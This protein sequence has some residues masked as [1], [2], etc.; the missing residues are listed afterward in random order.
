MAWRRTRYRR[1][2]PAQRKR[3][4]RRR[5]SLRRRRR[6]PLRPT[7][8]VTYK[9]QKIDYDDVTSSGAPPDGAGIK[10]AGMSVQISD[11]TN[12]SNEATRWDQF[13]IRKCRI[14]FI[15][16]FS[17]FDLATMSNTQATISMSHMPIIGWVVDRD[18]VT[19]PDTMDY[20]SRHGGKIRL[21]NKT[22][23]VTFTPTPLIDVYKAV[24]SANAVA[25]KPMWIDCTN[26]STPHYGLKYIIL[27]PT[28]AGT[29]TS[30][31]PYYV[32]TE[33]WVS[34]RNKLWATNWGN[35]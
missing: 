20:I 11:N 33:W 30:W 10:A 32:K 1:R 3:F 27:F 15:P 8:V 31:A 34:F 4:Q 19:A 6:T 2:R 14:T 28:D 9:F 35:C 29:S 22:I 16:A 23:S 13:K 25:P 26:N 21:F 12:A 24:T 5:R 17:G 18:D 7:R